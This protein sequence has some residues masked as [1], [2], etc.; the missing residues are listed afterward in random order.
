VHKTVEDIGAY[1]RYRDI[2]TRYE[3][4]KSTQN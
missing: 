3:K 1:G 2:D 4:L